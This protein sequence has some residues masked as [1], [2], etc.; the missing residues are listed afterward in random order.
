[1]NSRIQR[2]KAFFVTEKKHHAYRQAVSDP[3]RYARQYEKEG[4]D[5]LERTVQRLESVLE[6]EVPVVFPDEWICMTR[7]VVTI[8]EIFTEE[9]AEA[10]KKNCYVHERGKV[11]NI[12][13]DYTKLLH[14][15]L[16]GKR[17]ELEERKKYFE[18]KNLQKEAVYEAALIRIIDAMLKFVEKYRQEAKR[19][20]NEKAAALLE[21]VQQERPETFLEALVLFR[22]IHYCMWKSF[23]YHN[24]LGRFDQYLYPYYQI[25]IL[26]IKK[27]GRKEDLA[28]KMRWKFW[29][30][31]FLR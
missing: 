7:T 9:E 10:I 24:T 20:G 30:N 14:T 6:E 13:V 26:I 2:M 18:K 25:C 4:L 8:P 31:F 29:R 16:P 12:N 28:G 19:V 27:T 3:Y 15:G 22:V 17:K 23:H 5:D 21:K 11:C 1:M